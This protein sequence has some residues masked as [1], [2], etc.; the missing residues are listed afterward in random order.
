[1]TQGPSAL[2]GLPGATW[3]L[4][5]VLFAQPM[6]SLPCPRAFRWGDRRFPSANPHAKEA[7]TSLNSASQPCR[8]WLGFFFWQVL[9]S[10]GWGAGF[11][12]SLQGRSIRQVPLPCALI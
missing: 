8:V 10:Q 2:L 1:M 9:H 12:S 3:Q 4:V 5:L 11:D 6:T 7:H